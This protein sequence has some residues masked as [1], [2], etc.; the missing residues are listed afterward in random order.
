MP[1]ALNSLSPLS[2]STCRI[3]I[4]LMSTFCVALC[5]LFC[6]VLVEAKYT[7]ETYVSTIRRFHSPGVKD[8]RSIAQPSPPMWP[9]TT[10]C[11]SH[12]P[13]LSLSLHVTDVPPSKPPPHEH[14]PRQP[15]PV[16]CSVL[17]GVFFWVSVQAA[18]TRPQTS[19]N[20]SEVS[21]HGTEV[22]SLTRTRGAGKGS[23]LPSGWERWRVVAGFP[24]RSTGMPS[25]SWSSGK[26]R[27]LVPEPGARVPWRALSRAGLSGGVTKL[28]CTPPGTRE[29]CGPLL[30]IRVLNRESTQADGGNQNRDDPCG[31][32]F[33]H[34]CTRVG[35]DPQSEALM[36]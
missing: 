34:S 4:D 27:E 28:A 11:H 8:T 10:V 31:L 20:N 18:D 7:C 26:N 5:I 23:V 3:S 13:G 30:R 6:F 32:C 9:F 25:T 17:L 33:V 35:N 1:F 19:T 16:P 36:T 24:P 15:P 21:R 12:A 22:G 2:A 29:V 14:A